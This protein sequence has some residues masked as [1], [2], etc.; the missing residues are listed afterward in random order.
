MLV[1]NSI[2]DPVST[3]NSVPKSLYNKE[4]PNIIFCIT[5]NGGHLGWICNSSL[6]KPT[7]LEKVSLEHYKCLIQELNNNKIELK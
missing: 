3:I 4:N 1:I 6:K 2:D 5:E 7:W